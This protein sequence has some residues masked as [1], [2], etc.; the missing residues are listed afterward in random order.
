[1]SNA[2]PIR[3]IVNG[4]WEPSPPQPSKVITVVRTSVAKLLHKLSEHS[5]KPSDAA[6]NQSEHHEPIAAE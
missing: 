5:V 4:H 6:N 1:M 3:G 2:Q